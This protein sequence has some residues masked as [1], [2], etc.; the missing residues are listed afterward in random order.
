MMKAQTKVSVC[1]V[2][3]NPSKEKLLQ[4]LQSIVKQKGIH[5]QIVISDDG[6][7]NNCFAEAEAYLNAQGFSDYVL[8]P[9]EHNQGTV[10]NVEKGLLACDGEYVKTIS[11]GDCLTGEAVLAKWAEHLEASGKKWSFGNA[12]NYRDRDDGTMEC[13]PCPAHPQL[14]ADYEKHNDA[15]CRWNYTVLDDIALGAATLCETKL[16]LEYVQK[17]CGKVIYA[18]DNAYRLMAFDGFIADYYPENVV[19]YECGTGISTSGNALWAKRIQADWEATDAIMCNTWNTAD[20]TQQK[21]LHAIIRRKNCC[22][23]VRKVYRCMECGRIRL[24]L[25]LRFNKRM[26]DC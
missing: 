3:Y 16:L 8:L 13:F 26:T 7:S 18:E 5:I 15:Q 24:S 14:V 22:V 21:I 6:S 10:R 17:I 20:G 25:K 12:I 23:I 2:T 19:L 1:V 11:P 9:A 4:T